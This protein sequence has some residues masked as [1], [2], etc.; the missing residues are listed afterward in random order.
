M[1]VKAVAFDIDGTLY[2]N[3]KMK[4]NS[5]PFFAL[6][7]RLI[8]KFGEIRKEIRHL[9]HID[10]FYQTQAELFG[11]SLSITAD[12]AREI[13]DSFFYT[14]WEKTFSRIKP[15]GNIKNVVKSIREMNLKTAVLSDFPVGDKLTY[16]GLNNLWDVEVSSEQSGYLKPDTRP[17][18][19]LSDKLG[20]KPEEIIYVGNSYSYDVVGSKKAGM[21]AGHLSSSARD[22][23]IA[24]FTF[25]SYM[26]FLEKIKKFL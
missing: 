5:I 10:D 13:I 20:V 25:S 22:G 26:D 19:F 21:I 9:D 1:A 17:F 16:F 4:L 2:P 18:L 3:W 12:N 6:H 15:Y 11:S 14:Q 8:Y 24:D 23:S 7:P